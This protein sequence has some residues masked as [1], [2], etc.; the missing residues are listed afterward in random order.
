M[1]WTLNH[2]LIVSRILDR[3]LLPCLL[4]PTLLVQFLD[5]TTIPT[6]RIVR[7]AE[8]A[9]II[10]NME[11]Q[12]TTTTTMITTANENDDDDDDDDENQMLLRN[13]APQEGQEQQQ[14]VGGGNRHFSYDATNPTTPTTTTTT[15]LARTTTTT[16]SSSTNTSTSPSSSH[17]SSQN[18][19]LQYVYYEIYNQRLEYYLESESA[20]TWLWLIWAILLNIVIIKLEL[21]LFQDLIPTEENSKY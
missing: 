15:S 11:P 18:H 1:V 7:T 10:V 4:S 6:T 3:L 19:T 8:E 16:T 21:I 5:G 2:Y 20:R 14:Q 17:F 12:D 9:V 13:P